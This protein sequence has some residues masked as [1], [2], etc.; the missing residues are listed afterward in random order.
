MKSSD[1]GSLPAKRSDN[2]LLSSSPIY[3]I[4]AI[5]MPLTVLAAFI[6]LLEALASAHLHSI[7]LIT[8]GATGAIAA[9]FYFDFMKDIKS[10]H[11][12]ANI[13]GGIII[14]I[15]V[16]I[17]ASLFFSEKHFTERFLPN[18]A[19]IPASLCALYAWVYVIIL[20]QL[21]YARKQFEAISEQYEGQTLKEKL[22]EDSALLQYTDENINKAQRS[23]FFQL[24][25]IGILAL[26]CVI[27]KIT[28]PLPLYFLLVI[29]LISGVCIHGLF[30][31][32]KWEQYYAG[33]GINLSG[34][35]RIKRVLAII[36]LSLSG[37]V[38]A[39]LLASN[40]SII[41]FSV[42]MA[43]FA[44]L[45]SLFRRT[46]M[47]AEQPEKIDPFI[48]E[49]IP[50]GLPQFGEEPP[51][52]PIWDLILKYGSLILKYGLII[53]VSVLFI[54]FMISPLLNRADVRNLPFFRRLILIIKEWYT[55]I[56]NVIF[57]FFTHLKKNKDMK[58]NR[59]ND[60]DINRTARNIL[61]AYSAGKRRDVQK[62]VTLFARLIIWGANVRG[63]AWKPSHA[64]MEY[65]IYLSEASPVIVSSAD[66]NLFIQK[67]NT[68]I[69]R[70]GELFEKALYSADILSNDEK[71]EFKNLIE[72]ITSASNI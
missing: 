24:G 34:N 1:T 47:Q 17:L 21:F 43:F 53:L 69:I 35:D 72:E 33:E 67:Q 19:N 36:V 54:K 13:R 4:L 71:K 50:Q 66:N 68:G 39:S 9:S 5:Y 49:G 51:S 15:L 3:S 12:P 22:F 42:I 6:Y 57:S 48:N 44:W 14:I 8:G 26:S 16:Y 58:L 52:S 32:I 7:Y 41:P 65:C 59:Y 70:C 2:S 37:F 23:Y 31:I 60:E 46:P 28:I 38:I 11:K 64:P 29:I 40:N 30:A 63:T 62:S 55:S 25:I 10:S 56:V 61:N 20:K 18:Y 45:F 27:F